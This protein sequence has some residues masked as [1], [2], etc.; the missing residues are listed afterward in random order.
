VV[1]VVVVEAETAESAVKVVDAMDCRVGGGKPA[2]QSSAERFSQ[3][4]GL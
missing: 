1:F 4:I 3:L 2:S